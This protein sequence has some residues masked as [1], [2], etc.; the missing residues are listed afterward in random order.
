M[1]P[2]CTFTA[3]GTSSPASASRTDRATATPAFSCASSVLA[4]RCGVATTDSRSNNGESVH[5]SV[6]K[7]SM[8]AAA[9]R[10]SLSAA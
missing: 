6:A 2:P 10:P 8:P 9:T 7:T 1:T 5:G 3:S 4:P